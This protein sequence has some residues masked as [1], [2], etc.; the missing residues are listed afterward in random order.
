MVLFASAVLVRMVR[1]QDH[2]RGMTS[3]E[4][5]VTERPE[6]WLKPESGWLGPAGLRPAGREG[7]PGEELVVCPYERLRRKKTS[8]LR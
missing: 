3:A 7:S 6:C 5:Q 4:R 8:K 2:G 1:F